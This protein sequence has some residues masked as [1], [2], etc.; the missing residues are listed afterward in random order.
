MIIE[1]EDEN[2]LQKLEKKRKFLKLNS[3]L[4]TDRCYNKLSE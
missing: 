4:L 1:P 3:M 2:W